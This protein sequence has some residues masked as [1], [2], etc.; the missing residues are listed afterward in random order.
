MTQKNLK[1][2]TLLFFA[3]LLTMTTGCFRTPDFLQST[4]FFNEPAIIVSSS[5][6]SAIKKLPQE[7]QQKLPTEVVFYTSQQA[8]DASI[9]PQQ[10]SNIAYNKLSLNFLWT[11]AQHDLSVVG[12]TYSNMPSAGQTATHNGTELIITSEFSQEN[13]SLLAVL[14][15]D[16]TGSTDWLVS[17]S[18][19]SLVQEETSS[20]LLLIRNVRPNAILTATV[21]SASECYGN[22][23]K[24]FTGSSLS[25]FLEYQPK[26]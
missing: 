6:Y 24:D 1:K 12:T 25:E 19:K 9:S 11:G 23:C 20:R 4:G 5:Y 2:H 17:Y 13:L 8:T 26:Y 18:Y 3:L 15:W 21:L 16:E 10:F 14:D 7:L 22:N